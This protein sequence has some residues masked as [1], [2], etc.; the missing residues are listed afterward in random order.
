MADRFLRALGDWLD[1]VAN[2]M[3]IYIEPRDIWVGVFV[4]A[5]GITYVCPVPCL[6]IAW[7]RKA[8]T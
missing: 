6:V 2:R 5:K 4:S 1:A 8:R 3:R 7:K